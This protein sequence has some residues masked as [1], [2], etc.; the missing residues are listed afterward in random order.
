MEE[1]Q[2]LHQQQLLDQQQQLQ[3][4]N[5]Q[6]SQRRVPSPGRLSPHS[7]THAPPGTPTKKYNNI[8]SLS[9]LL[10]LPSVCYVT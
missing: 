4:Q 7:T 5:K 3:E 6:L 9:N 1:N 2:Q 10:C 8:Y